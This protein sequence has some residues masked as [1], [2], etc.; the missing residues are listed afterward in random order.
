MGSTPLET[1]TSKEKRDL[2]K[3]N[4]HRDPTLEKNETI[5]GNKRIINVLHEKRVQ[6]LIT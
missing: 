6:I 3:K 5:Q 2:K 1:H 4:V